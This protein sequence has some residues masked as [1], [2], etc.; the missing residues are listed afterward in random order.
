MPIRPRAVR[1]AAAPL[2]LTALVPGAA[3]PAGA[4]GAP[5][6]THPSRDHA[7]LT[8]RQPEGDADELGVDRPM[9]TRTPGTDVS[10]RQGDVARST[11]R[12]D[13]AR[14]A[15]AKATEGTSC[16]NPSFAQQYNGSHSAGMIRGAY[17]L[18][19]PDNSGGTAQADCFVDH[20]GG[21]SA[22]GGTHPPAFDI[23]YNPYGATCHG[24]SRSAMAGWI[25]DFGT[26]V[27]SR[28]G[29][30]P[31]IHTT[32]DRRATCTGNSS[33]FASTSPLWSAR[34]STSVGTLPAGRSH[35][36]IRQY[37]DSGT[38]PGDQ[39]SFNGAYDRLQALALG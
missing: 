28:T 17:H 20:E 24:P 4:A 32:T 26:T 31:L 15:H 1:V 27:H 21:W 9:V 11:A 38:F 37:A 36:T 14:L 35:R 3:A 39:D 33:A 29:R 23:E 22:D 18:A 5:R 30:Y 8:L 25:R 7:C 16:T 6:P 34:Y 12:A 13:G 19:L 2:A 10:G